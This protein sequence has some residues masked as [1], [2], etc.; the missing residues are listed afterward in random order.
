MTKTKKESCFVYWIR[1]KECHTDIKSQGYV[2]ITSKTVEH[3]WKAHKSNNKSG[4]FAHYPLYRAFAKYGEE[5]LE[6]LTLC[7]GSLDYCLYMENNLRPSNGIGWNSLI[8]GGT[9]TKGQKFSDEARAKMRASAKARITPEERE[10]RRVVTRIHSNKPETIAKMS[11]LI[12]SFDWKLWRSPVAN[13]QIWVFADKIYDLHVKYPNWR[14]RTMC[15]VLG[16]EHDSLLIMFKAFDNGW[17][18][19]NDERFIEFQSEQLNENSSAF[20]L[21]EE[22]INRRIAKELSPKMPWDNPNCDKQVWLDAAKYYETF[23]KD[24]SMGNRKLS[25]QHGVTDAKLYSIILKF[26]AGWNPSNCPNWLEFRDNY[27]ETQHGT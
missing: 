24:P 11:A 14:V 4:K 26:K 27:K 22:A 8:G 5:S 18:P 15:N 9:T 23:S 6:V 13:K 21:D 20:M 19:K 10:K 16:L 3:R 17:I 25:K 2:G 1:L 7:E 12:K